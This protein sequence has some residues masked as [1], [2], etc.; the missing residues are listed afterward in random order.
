MISNRLDF[1][2]VDAMTSK[3]KNAYTGEDFVFFV[4]YSGGGVAASMVAQRLESSL[5]VHGIIKIGS[6][7]INAP[8]S[9]WRDRTVS[10]YREGDVVHG[11]VA[12]P[13][14]Y[15]KLV[16]C[17]SF[18]YEVKSYFYR[19]KREEIRG[20]TGNGDGGLFGVHTSYFKE[21]GP[22][23][24]SKGTTNLSKTVDAVVNEIIW[25]SR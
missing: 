23:T 13:E 9:S 3:V 20:L 24:D 17:Q 1:G 21:D 19:P 22:A 7:Q 8:T 2:T 15:E 10:I 14:F 11:V 6:P 25:R 12:D 5:Y 18:V 4:G 16:L